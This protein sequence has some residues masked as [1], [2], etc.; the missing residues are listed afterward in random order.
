MGSQLCITTIP[1]WSINPFNEYLRY[2]LELFL[3]L[4][5]LHLFVLWDIIWYHLLFWLLELW[6][7]LSIMNELQY[8]S[9]FMVK[10]VAIYSLPRCLIILYICDDYCGVSLHALGTRLLQ[11]CLRH[12]PP[13][14]VCTQVWNLKELTEG[15]HKNAWSMWLNLTQREKAYRVRTHWG[16]TGKYNTYT[17]YAKYEWPFMIVW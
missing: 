15:H 8:T 5:L 13:G 12:S 7:L 1:L 11:K 14:V 2:R 17:L 10:G 6:A 9:Y 3:Q 4:V 16:L